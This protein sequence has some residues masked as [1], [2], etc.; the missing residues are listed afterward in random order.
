MGDNSTPSTTVGSITR[1]FVSIYI[2]KENLIT[3]CERQ[4]TENVKVYN[5]NIAVP[6]N[7]NEKSMFYTST[8]FLFLVLMIEKHWSL[9]LFEL[10]FIHN[11]IIYF[12]CKIK[13]RTIPSLTYMLN[14][15]PP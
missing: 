5:K 3:H 14:N 1:C 4:G 6:F 7:S 2:S 9:K 11:F 10:M 12:N 13:S 8:L 15:L